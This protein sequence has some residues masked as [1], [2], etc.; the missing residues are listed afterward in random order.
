MDL[1]AAAIK[2]IVVANAADPD[3][4]TDLEGEAQDAIDSMTNCELLKLIRDLLP[5]E[6]KP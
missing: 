2:R 5:P 4:T 1:L 3:I 6:T